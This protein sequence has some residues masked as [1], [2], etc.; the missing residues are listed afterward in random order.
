MQKSTLGIEYL[1]LNAWT[2]KDLNKDSNIS[3]LIILMLKIYYNV[4]SL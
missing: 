4:V 2:I 1:L 3:I